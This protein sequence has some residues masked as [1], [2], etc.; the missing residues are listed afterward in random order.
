MT[1][2]LVSLL[3]VSALSL[4]TFAKRDQQKEGQ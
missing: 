1:I 3:L 2:T 4:A